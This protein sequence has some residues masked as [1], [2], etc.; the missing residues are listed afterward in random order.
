MKVLKAMR[1]IL[2]GIAV[3]LLAV[4]G[5]SGYQLRVISRN[6]AQ[7]SEIREWVMQYHPMSRAANP[8]DLPAE[9]YGSPKI[10]QSIVDLQAA[11]PN[12]VGWLI[13]PNTGVDYPFVQGADND[14][15]L[16]SDLNQ[17][18]SAAGTLFMDFRNSREFSDFNTIIYGHHMRSGSKF[19]SLQS[20]DNRA[21]FEA[22][23]SGT[24]FLSDKT[25]EIE[26]MAFAVIQPDDAMI[27][28]PMIM[29]DTDKIAFLDH[30]ES[31]A[32]HYRD[33]GITLNDRIVTLST[34]NYEFDNARM[35]LVGRLNEN[36][37]T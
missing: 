17:R 6:N 34:C 30:V 3:V 27:Y 32:R 23:R 22:N 24:I 26:F 25:Y 16:H 35:V 33:I 2:L 36:P 12:V 7:E 29:T 20:F 13:I 31:I 14:Q 5:Y 8:A 18:R 19:G 21:F 9:S 10:N 11:L 37:L 28:N 15:Y 4:I 1:I